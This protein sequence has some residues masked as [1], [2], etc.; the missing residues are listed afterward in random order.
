MP[1]LIG[2][3]VVKSAR[4]IHRCRTCFAPAVLPGESYKRQTYA[5]D[6]MVYDWVSCRPC[7]EICGEVHS[8]VLDDEG[9]TSEDYYE[10]A[11]ELRD[12][13]KHGESARAYL[14]RRA[15]DAS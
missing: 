12:D 2:E 1:E 9:V 4:K 13:P 15:G 6:G 10:W 5:Y 3:R 14:K 11:D 8:W 7:D